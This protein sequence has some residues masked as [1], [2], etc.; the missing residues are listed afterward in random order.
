MVILIKVS[1]LVDLGLLYF[2]S[3]KAGLMERSNFLSILIVLQVHVGLE[4]QIGVYFLVVYYS[5][6]I[7]YL[8]GPEY[9]RISSLFH[10]FNYQLLIN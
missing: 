10:I 7:A 4:L 9:V 8:F 2:F 6:S 3:R 1:K 5:W